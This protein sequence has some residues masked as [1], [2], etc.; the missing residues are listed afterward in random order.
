LGLQLLFGSISSESNSG[1]YLMKL[2][3]IIAA[4]LIGLG[5]LVGSAWSTADKALSRSSPTIELL[6]S[7]GYRDIRITGWDWIT[8]DAI[9]RPST[10]FQATTATGIRCSGAVV[11]DSDG[12]TRIR[13][14]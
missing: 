7:Q 14:H 9:W 2:N 5:L 12:I 10:G 6:E 4:S 13:F 11:I 8:A 3:R 1:E